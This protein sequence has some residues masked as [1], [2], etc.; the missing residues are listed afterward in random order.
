MH[1]LFLSLLILIVSAKSAFTA[2]LEISIKGEG[3]N[4][5][6]VIDLFEDVAPL[7]VERMVELAR[8]GKYDGIAFHRVIDGFMAQTGDVQF[9]KVG[10]DFSMV[11]RGGSEMPDLP[12]EFSNIPFDRGIV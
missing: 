8:K 7:H 10:G 5:L 2:K 6:V 3:A 1:R 12:A 11:G 4:G 9:G